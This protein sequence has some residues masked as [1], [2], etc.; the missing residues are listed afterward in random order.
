L[1]AFTTPEGYLTGD[2]TG[3]ALNSFGI[4]GDDEVSANTTL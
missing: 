2:A 1:E 4:Y 3:G